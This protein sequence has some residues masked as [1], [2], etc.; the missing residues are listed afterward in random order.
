M[1]TW[2]YGFWCE[3][4]QRQACFPRHGAPWLGRF[5]EHCSW[6]DADIDRLGHFW[7]QLWCF[8]WLETRNNQSPPAAEFGA[9]DLYILINFQCRTTYTLLPW[10]ILPANP[11][12]HMFIILNC[13]PIFCLTYTTSSNLCGSAFRFSQST[14]SWVYQF[15]T[16]EYQWSYGPLHE[17]QNAIGIQL[18]TKRPRNTKT[19]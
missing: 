13:L 5:Q 3:V 4:G 16:Q 2:K 1:L 9:Q 18:S 11:L 14:P 10:S 17:I 8:M 6:W 19:P 12:V 15:F 7:N